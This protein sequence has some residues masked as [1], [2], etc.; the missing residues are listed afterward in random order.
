MAWATL[1]SGQ[2]GSSAQL[3]LTAATEPGPLLALLS[4]EPERGLDMLALA[5]TKMLTEPLRAVAATCSS[6]S[7]FTMV[8]I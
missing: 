1:V 8:S 5:L 4:Q 6:T 7:T 2:L 3:K